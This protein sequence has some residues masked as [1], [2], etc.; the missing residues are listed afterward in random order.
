MRR[1]DVARSKMSENKDNPSESSRLWHKG[2]WTEQQKLYWERAELIK[3]VDALRKKV[4][5]L[6][7]ALITGPPRSWDR[8]G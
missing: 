5:M 4:E 7:N 3:E 1:I 2:K 8:R 6:E